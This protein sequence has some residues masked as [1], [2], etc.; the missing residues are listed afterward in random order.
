MQQPRDAVEP[1]AQRIRRDNEQQRSQHRA[2]RDTTGEA[3]ILRQR[4]VQPRLRRAPLQKARDPHHQM[5]FHAVG[6]KPLD[7]AA[8]IN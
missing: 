8:V 2:L 7:N 6:Q 1:L 5:P 4:T 3:D